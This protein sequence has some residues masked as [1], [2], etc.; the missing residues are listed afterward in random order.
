MTKQIYLDYMA[1]T[2]LIPE[3]LEKMLP[4]YTTHFGNPSSTSHTY[5]VDARGAVEEARTSIAA[6]FNAKA[7]EIIF[8][9]GATEAD[10][11][12][13]VGAALF[14]KTS[15]KHLITM[16]TEHKAVLKSFK[17]L[18]EEHGFK[19]TYLKPQTSGLLDITQ[20]EQAITNETTLVSIMHVNNETGVIQDIAAIAKLLKSRGIIFHVDAAQSV[21]KLAIDLKQIPVALMSFSGHK[22]YGPKGI[23]AL[24]IRLDP[25]VRLQ[26]INYGGAQEGSTRSGTLPTALIVGMACA[27]K[28]VHQNLAQE[29]ARILKLRNKFWNAISDIN[30]I[31]LH[32]SLEKRVAGSLNIGFNKKISLEKIANELAFSKSSACSTQ[33]TSYVLEAMSVPY[34]LAENSLRLSFG[35]LT[36][37][38]DI[39]RC[40]ELFNKELACAT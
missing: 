11:L 28:I 25:R 21:G 30:G 5:G 35:R 7:Q 6:N 20:L 33:D 26:A 18:E 15:G 39:N 38:Q 40:I 12:A 32:G 8:T 19:V 2:P 3:A 1:T 16:Q 4:F 37:E 31:I 10:N 34:K 23:G 14:Y 13:I 24:F 27:F 17:F 29:Q 36:T 9:S 22:C